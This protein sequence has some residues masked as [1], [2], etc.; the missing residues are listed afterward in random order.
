MAAYVPPPA[1]YPVK[2]P[3]FLQ[4]VGLVGVVGG[5]TN[6]PTECDLKVCIKFISIVMIHHKIVRPIHGSETQIKKV[7]KLARSWT[8]K[9][10]KTHL[11][12]I[13][14]THFCKP[15]RSSEEFWYPLDT[16]QSLDTKISKPNLNNIKKTIIRYNEIKPKQYQK[17][18]LET[19]T[20][21]RH[22]K[23]IRKIIRFKDHQNKSKQYWKQTRLQVQTWESFWFWTYPP[24]PSWL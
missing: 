13:R 7:W 21:K 10:F 19:K 9:D 4:Q 12:N 24:W 8:N 1:Y 16:K 2:W 5:S 23:T 22:L 3:L 20:S 17:Q 18:S 14:S 6:P 15:K 11:N